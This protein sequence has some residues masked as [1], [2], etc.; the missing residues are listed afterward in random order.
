MD[1]MVNIYSPVELRQLVADYNDK[2]L[3]TVRPSSRY[4][5]LSVVK[6]ART[7]FFDNLWDDFLIEC[8]GLIIDEDFNVVVHPMTKVFNYGENGRHI[9]VPKDESLMC[10]KKYNGFMLAV[11]NHSKYGLIFST[12]GSTDSDYCILGEQYYRIYE[13]TECYQIAEGSTA[14]FE[15]CA[16]EDPHIISEVVGCYYLGSRSNREWYPNYDNIFE[17]SLN[18]LF[19]SKEHVEGWVCYRYDHSN[20]V[21]KIKTPY[22]LKHKLLS[23]GNMAKIDRA[24]SNDFGNLSTYMA[25]FD[26]EFHDIAKALLPH[27]DAF[28]S[29]DEQAR[30]TF[31]RNLYDQH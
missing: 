14:V 24:L 1:A 4:P 22:Y 9:D 15:I 11:T 13:T 6:Y 12:T 7:V 29:L 10:S 8:R 16:Q 5:G 28:I 21:F 25:N 30:L 2:K 20:C 27:R 3:I 26:E 18:K 31:L 19:A 17:G 23:R